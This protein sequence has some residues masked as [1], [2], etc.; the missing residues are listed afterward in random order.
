MSKFHVFVFLCAC[1]CILSFNFTTQFSLM[2]L[3]V[4]SLC[5]HAC[6]VFIIINL[7][8]TLD[9]LIL[10]IHASGHRVPLAWDDG[11]AISCT[12][13]EHVNDSCAPPPP[14]PP[15]PPAAAA[16][17]ADAVMSDREVVWCRPV[18]HSGEETARDCS[19]VRLAYMMQSLSERRRRR[20]ISVMD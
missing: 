4:L 10:V 6:H 17:A 14:P 16:A 15:P 13:L 11:P 1:L 8:F 3:S 5:K 9:L 2:V 19:S 7:Y 18:F 12:P 20:A